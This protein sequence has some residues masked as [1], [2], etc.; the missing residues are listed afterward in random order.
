MVDV[1]D[2]MELI[3]NTDCSL[4]SETVIAFKN[5][6]AIDLVKLELLMKGVI[7]GN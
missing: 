2:K 1:A 3:T 5:Y 4:I 6:G 7:F